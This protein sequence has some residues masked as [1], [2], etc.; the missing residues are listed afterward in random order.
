VGVG[1]RLRGRAAVGITGSTYL[2]RTWETAASSEDVVGGEPVN[3]TTRF[4]SNGALNDV[5]LAFAWAFSSTLQGGVAYHAYTGENRMRISWEF[6]DSTRFGSVS[7]T[8][9]LGLSGNGVSL[10]ATWQPVRNLAT[11]AYVRLGGD[12][13]LRIQDTLISKARTPA[14]QGIAL[15]YDGVSGTIIAAGWERIHW[16]ALR[17]LGSATLSVRDADR[18]AVGI[19]TRGPSV[20]QTPVFLRAGVSR[21]D[22]PFAA[23]GHDVRETLLG[24]GGGYAIAAGRANIDLALQ[25]AQ[26][27]AGDARERA[28]LLSFGLVILP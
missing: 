14:Q 11:S 12:A 8:S 5:R 2:D 23:A 10:G 13:R 28:W 24:F 20:A 19:E 25:R 17:D 7:Q 9:T 1:A 15:R 4:A 22:L 26:R 27:T 18:F 21:R 16:S 3:V 6:P